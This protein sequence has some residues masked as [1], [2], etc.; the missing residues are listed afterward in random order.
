K[1]IPARPRGQPQPPPVYASGVFRSKPCAN[2]RGDL[3]PLWL[4][5]CIAIWVGADPDDVDVISGL[6]EPHGPDRAVADRGVVGTEISQSGS[7]GHVRP[8]GGAAVGRARTDL[9][10]VADLHAAALRHRLRPGGEPGTRGHRG[11]DLCDA[12]RLAAPL[13]EAGRARAAEGVAG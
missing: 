6:S 7:A 12:V 9:P 3:T 13:Q 1:A 10:L 2:L 11:G 4:R 8:A 5:Y